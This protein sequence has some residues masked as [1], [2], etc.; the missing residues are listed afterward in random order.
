M[1][2]VGS[3]NPLQ[4]SFDRDALTFVKVVNAS[5]IL[6]QRAGAK[7]HHSGT[8]EGARG[9]GSIGEKYGL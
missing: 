9:A 4:A 1:S 3:P 8:H 7:V 6:Q 5:E 2:A